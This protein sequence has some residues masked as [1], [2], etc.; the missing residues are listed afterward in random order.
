MR[1]LYIFLYLFIPTILFGAGV[2]LEFQPSAPIQGDP[3]KIEI[4][5]VKK[6][7][8]IKKF[9]FDSKEIPF[10]K[11]GSDIFGLI[12]IDLNKKPGLY[13]AQVTL[14]NGKTISQNVFIQER[15][16]YRAPL[17]IPQKLGGDTAQ[18]VVTVTSNLSKENSVLS[19][20]PL[21]QKQLWKKSFDFPVG[22]PFITDPY[23]YSRDTVSTTITH[24]GTDFRAPTG[25]KIFAINDG[26]V[27]LSKS[28]IVYGDT[29]VIDH[30]AGVE[31]LYMHLSETKVKAGEKI[32]K[33]DLIGLSGST[34]YAEAP[35]LHLSIRINKISID[36][37]T[38]FKYLSSGN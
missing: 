10:I 34:G 8:D 21:S 18:G 4:L 27:S 23:G 11:Q 12:G 15:K 6:V 17:S 3:L 9:S 14:R 38:F 25:T 7:S 5:G 30:G 22:I 35:H 28:F 16:K 36:P 33:G 24:K 32:K 29:V 20:L 1:N 2:N 26:V 13:L 19:A 31:S 37:M